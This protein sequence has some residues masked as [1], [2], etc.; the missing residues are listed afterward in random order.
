MTAKKPQKTGALQLWGPEPVP[1]LS[2][3]RVR[4][5]TP[6]DHDASRGAPLLLLF[7]GQNIF[8]DEPSFAGGWHAHRAVDRLARRRPRPVVAAI[9][10]GG[11]E[12]IHELSPW[13]AHG[14]RGQLDRL[15]AWAADSLLPRLHSHFSAGAGPA[16][17]VIGGS[18]LGGLAALYAHF[19]RPDVFGGALAMS[20][21][22][23][24]AQRRI[25]DWLGA[26]ST[27]WTSRVYL[28]CGALEGRGAM[29][30][31]ARTLAEQ[32][33]HRG[34][35]DDRLRFR[36]DRLGAHNERSWRRRLPNALRFFYRAP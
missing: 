5:Y 10:H 17:T 33:G 7:D 1:G 30:T 27:P 18:S 12:R 13:G 21:S 8:D 19:H 6:P 11:A 32:L 23:W 24:F 2:D 34:Y 26:A 35:G 28:D 36:A 15:L 20:P 4:V 22:L 31:H 25:F 9:D 16:A 14:S 29:L 3:R